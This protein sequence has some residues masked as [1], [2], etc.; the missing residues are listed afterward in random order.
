M[1]RTRSTGLFEILTCVQTRQEFRQPAREDL[2]PTRA[3][4]EVAQRNLLLS[5]V[6]TPYISVHTWPSPAGG[7][8]VPGPSI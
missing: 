1:R 6:L 8:V 4:R 2:A 3:R 7:P 5:S